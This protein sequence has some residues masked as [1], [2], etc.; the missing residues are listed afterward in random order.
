MTLASLPKLILSAAVSTAIC[1]SAA[2]ASYKEGER[3]FEVEVILFNQLGDKS[4]LK[5][6]FPTI[7]DAA[8]MPKYK[9]VIDLL[10]PYLSP[11]IQ[12]LKALLPNC[13]DIRYPKS[14]V[15]QN[16]HL[17]ALFT[18]KSLLEIEALPAETNEAYT[19]NQLLDGAEGFK[20]T[21]SEIN[22]N[23]FA[24]ATQDSNS[25]NTLSE[26][27]EES[28]ANSA[29]DIEEETYTPLTEKQMQLVALAEKAFND[30]QFENY[31]ALP[32]Q[33][34][35]TLCRIDESAFEEYIKEHPEF[36]YNGI[37]TSVMPKTIDSVEDVFSEQPY[38]LSESSLQLQEIVLQ[39]KR[40]KNFRPLLHMGWRHA[41]VSRNNAEAYRIYAG[42]N[43]SL[44]YQEKLEVYKRNKEIA[45]RMQQ[46]EQLAL[47]DAQ[48]SNTATESGIQ[49]NTSLAS[50]SPTQ[51]DIKS[52]QQ[53]E[54]LAF[55][56]A[57]AKAINNIVEKIE[58]LDVTDPDSISNIKGTATDI[59]LF[60]VSE[61]EKALAEKLVAPEEP[62]QPWFLDGLFRVHL[63]HYLYITADFNVVNKNLAQQ[64]TDALK[65][66]SKEELKAIRFQQN[67][68]VISGEIHYF[69]HPY[70]GM[71]VQIRR[72]ERPEKE[73]IDESTS[74]KD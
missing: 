33:S 23:E 65:N 16:N 26:N 2:A 58:T 24:S 3:W 63:N 28:D 41:P 27:S 48:N 74:D 39:L 7:E 57:Y 50:V 12:T 34:K 40:S 10:A 22:E 52:K 32:K 66:D 15:E 21:E 13:D 44:N 71:V 67:R 1:S 17:P 59:N 30:I 45:L 60:T 42:D 55:Q 73:V 54:K 11:D 61:D 68:R 35:R 9:N 69:D 56:T 19:N 62:I 53:Q 14:L 37:K 31:Q 70:I 25:F 38:L 8:P 49:D 36:V 72:H 4:L 18:E 43:F 20:S 5:E 6:K 51:N 64:A 47:L 29:A 46:Q